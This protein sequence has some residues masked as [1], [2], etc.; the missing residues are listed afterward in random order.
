MTPERWN[1]V[2]S[3]TE[4]AKQRCADDRE[5]YLEEIYEADPA[6]GLDVISLIEPDETASSVGSVQAPVQQAILAAGDEVG[7]YRI[8]SLLGQGGMG[9]V[10]QAKDGR[11]GRFVALKFLPEELERYPHIRARFLQEA[12]VAAALDHPFICK[13]YEIGEHEGR[14]F[15]A[16]EYVE[17]QTLGEKL[18]RDRPSLADSI[19]LGIEIADALEKAHQK[20]VIHRD[21]KPQNIMITSEGHIKLM[22]FGLAR[23]VVSSDDTEDS[24]CATPLT[25]NLLVG[26]LAYMS[27]EQFE[28]DAIDHRSDI[29]SFGIILYEMLTGT[30][31]FRR[32]T[33]LETANAIA[34]DPPN[35][36]PEHP[37]VPKDLQHVVNRMLEKDPAGRQQS[38]REIRRDLIDVQNAFHADAG[39]R[40]KSPA[41]WVSIAIVVS[42][43]VLV[44][45]ILYRSKPLRETSANP[46]DTVPLTSY[47]REER[48]PSFSPDARRVVFSWNGGPGNNFD[49]YAKALGSEDRTRLT[50]NSA[51]DM[52][53]DWSPDGN[54]IAFARL[55]A[56]TDRENGLFL[57][58][59]NGGPETQLREGELRDPHWAPDSKSIVFAAVPKPP[60]VSSRIHLFSTINLKES[61]LT[62]PPANRGDTNPVFSP[63]GR[64]LAFVRWTGQEAGD[65][66]L[67][68][69]ESRAVRRLTNRNRAVFGL[70]FGE[71]G[72]EIVFASN[73][74]REGRVWRVPVS[75]GEPVA[76]AITAE[77]LSLCYSPVRHLLAYEENFNDLNIWR[78]PGTAASDRANAPQP[79]IASTQPDLNPDYSPDGTKI[80][81]SSRRTG[82][83]EIW[84]SDSEGQNLV[85]LTSLG[86]HS[87]T[88][89]WSPD[90][91]KIAFDSRPEG[92]SDIFMMDPK[93]RSPFRLTDNR[94]DDI[95]PSWSRDGKWIYFGSDRSGKWEVWKVS[96][97]DGKTIQVTHNGG[98]N[99]VESPDG[100]YLYYLKA[101]YSPLWRMP[102]AGGPE[103]MVINELIFW[104]NWKLLPEGIFFSR[105]NSFFLIGYEGDG[106][107]VLRTVQREADW[108]GPQWIA[109]S[110]DRKWILY[111]SFD[112]EVRDIM[113]VQNFQ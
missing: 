103:T 72:R 50:V 106:R 5:A 11:L 56:R 95:I 87:G 8:V 4:E 79:L 29:F 53:P 10:Y 58:P 113:L 90:G 23:R 81:F 98:W 36:F 1:K 65:I 22:D 94:A 41:G 14:K 57:I 17:G 38:V 35:A 26:T 33:K 105:N 61:E 18:E 44:G 83:S 15:I 51:Q 99:A 88:P 52:Y 110:P 34:N 91:R 100:R 45:L 25:G 75:G 97:E 20:S 92:D 80:L 77:I 49:L 107:R 89:R 9:R 69:M 60:S 76:T 78:M 21:L 28:G 3:L 71:D 39:D 24:W 47:P 46:F 73:D 2:R 68:D 19:R 96:P 32:P 63:D 102:L 74:G 48:W 43:L 64:V 82:S 67:L 101:A 42:V 54:K 12:R 93:G 7:P 6:L 40:L 31:P 104:P 59:A 66:Y 30:H 37:K 55:G 109:L 112:H 70:A 111:S 86:Q 84:M 16:M 108:E 27:P 62:F 85:Q 13:I